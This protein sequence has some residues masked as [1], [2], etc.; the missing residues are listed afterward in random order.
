MI[1][2]F[3][4]IILGFKAACEVDGGVCASLVEEV[5]SKYQNSFFK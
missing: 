4:K 3:S 5:V 2:N 1:D